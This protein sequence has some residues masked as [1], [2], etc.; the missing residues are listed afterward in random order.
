MNGT[1]HNTYNGIYMTGG[2]GNTLDG[3]MAT[4][5]ED[6]IEL[7]NTSGNTLNA[8]TMDGNTYMGIRLDGSDTNTISGNQCN[9]ETDGIYLG[10]SSGNT[11]TGNTTDSNTYNG[12]YL[13]TSSGNTI[14]GNTASGN[15]D[16]IEMDNGADGNTVTGNTTNGNTSMGINA[17][18]SDGHLVTGNVANDNLI[19]IGVNSN[20][21]VCDNIAD[22]NVTT[23]PGYGRGFFVR[24]NNN[25]ISGNSSDSSDL[26][27]EVRGQN[28]V[29]DANDF[30]NFVRSCIYIEITAGGNEIYG[31]TCANGAIGVE[32]GG[33]NNLLYW[34]RFINYATPVSFFGITY[35][36]SFNQPYPIGGNYWSSW[37]TP[38]NDS[39]GFV[40][41]PYVFTYGQDNLPRVAPD[42]WSCSVKPPLALAT[43]SIYWASMQDYNDGILSIDYQVSND[44]GPKAYN[45]QITGAVNT[46][47]VTLVT[48]VP[49]S[50]GDIG[51]CCGGAS[52]TL[53]YHIPTGV[54]SFMNTVQATAYDACGNPYIYP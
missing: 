18:L 44:T 34:N 25:R 50:L 30:T 45:V 2:S 20:S 26:A 47:G 4:G 7:N 13:V 21:E 35:G 53:Q 42:D 17:T 14:S 33:H 37:T 48:T 54:Q 41:N 38:D 22:H 28:N 51:A 3:N 12:I 10:A 39:D 15:D 36:N 31:N 27:V 8:N 40:D 16:G 24:G 29:L 5:N 52:L 11:L 19:G 6:G 1:D 23:G 49:V 9:G 32:M 43:T 46:N